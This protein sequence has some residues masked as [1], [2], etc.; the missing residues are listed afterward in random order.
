MD[1]SGHSISTVA[2]AVLQVVKVPLGFTQKATL[3]KIGN[4]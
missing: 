1:A 3:W 4:V 2:L